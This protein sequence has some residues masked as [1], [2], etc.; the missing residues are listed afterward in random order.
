MTLRRPFSAF[1]ASMA[2]VSS[3]RLLVVSR[4]PPCMRL[5]MLAGDQQYAPAARTRVP[6]AGAVG[7]NLNYLGQN[8]FATL[9][10]WVRPA[11]RRPSVCAA[12]G[13]TGV[14]VLTRFWAVSI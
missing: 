3:I 12:N 4:S 9:V 10:W 1:S 7:I 13:R 8:G 2:A 6:P 14:S 11:R 5:A